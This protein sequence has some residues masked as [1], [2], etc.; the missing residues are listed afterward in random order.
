MEAGFKKK[1]EEYS[2]RE[3]QEVLLYPIKLILER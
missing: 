2:S 1:N 3:M